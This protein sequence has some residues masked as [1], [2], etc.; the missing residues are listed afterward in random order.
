LP[1]RIDAVVGRAL[2]RDR[3]RRYPTICA[4]ASD[5]REVADHLGGPLDQAA[6]SEAVRTL[7]VEALTM[8]AP[9]V[10]HA[11][12]RPIKE[13]RPPV[14]GAPAGPPAI[15]TAPPAPTGSVQLRD[16]SVWLGRRHRSRWWIALAALV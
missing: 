14:V 7:G 11:L 6:L 5:L 8:R 13:A 15:N 2:E 3:D 16:G 9:Q 4:F 10:S 12:G 1:P